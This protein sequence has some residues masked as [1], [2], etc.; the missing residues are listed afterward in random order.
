MTKAEQAAEEY[1]REKTFWVGEDD[2][3]LAEANDCKKCF[4][5]G[6][7]WARQNPGWVKVSEQLPEAGDEIIAYFYPSKSRK[8]LTWVAGEVA[9]DGDDLFIDYEVDGIALV[10]C[11]FWCKLPPKPEVE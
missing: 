3:W 6:V 7:E 8:Q 4:L 1:V 2:L 9:N 5:A 10:D 11:E